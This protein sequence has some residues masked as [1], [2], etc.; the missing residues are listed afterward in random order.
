MS[1]PNNEFQCGGC[2]TPKSAKS[3]LL[4]KIFQP[5]NRFQ[6]TASNFTLALA[7]F[8]TSKCRSTN[9]DF[10]RQKAPNKAN[11][12]I[13][14][15]FQSVILQT[16]RRVTWP[17][18]RATISTDWGA[19]AKGHGWR[20]AFERKTNWAQKSNL[21]CL[22]CDHCKQTCRHATINTFSVWSGLFNGWMVFLTT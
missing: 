19:T 3:D 14:W 2:K 18:L 16:R 4:N 17:V 21:F 9:F 1:L 8:R 22:L 6:Q 13:A 7:A 11:T 10:M 12:F 5:V 20:Q 15:I